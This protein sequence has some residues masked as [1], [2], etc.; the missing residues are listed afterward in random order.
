[1]RCHPPHSLHPGR[2]IP[3]PP[4]RSATASKTEA[5]HVEH[6]FSDWL[7]TPMHLSHSQIQYIL[8]ISFWWMKVITSGGFAFALTY[9][10]KSP[11]PLR[12]IVFPVPMCRT[13]YT[14]LFGNQSCFVQWDLIGNLT[15]QSCAYFLKST[16]KL[17][18]E[19]K[20]QL[21]AILGCILTVLLLLLPEVWRMN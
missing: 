5:M 11:E 13:A 7:H 10:I 4:S 17:S 21:S 18:T 1:M 8:F 16:E 9:R 14:W 2:L 12:H 3:L 6:G 19:Y 15:A 20:V